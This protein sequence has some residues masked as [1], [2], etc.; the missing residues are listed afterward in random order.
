[1][2]DGFH[3]QVR[4]SNLLIDKYIEVKT[5]ICKYKNNIPHRPDFESTTWWLSSIVRNSFYGID[6]RDIDTLHGWLLKENEGVAEVIQEADVA[7]DKINHTRLLRRLETEGFDAKKREQYYISDPLVPRGDVHYH[8]VCYFRGRSGYLSQL[9]QSAIANREGLY[10][11]YF[12]P[13]E[14]ESGLIRYLDY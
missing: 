4:R 6:Y 3:D 5:I 2:I 10:F 14:D 7:I 13:E 9:R 11:D 8:I 1:M 12:G